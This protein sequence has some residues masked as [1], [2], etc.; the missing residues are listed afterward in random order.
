[1]KRG[2]HS[3]GEKQRCGCRTLQDYWGRAVLHTSRVKEGG[4][5][6]KNGEP[7]GVGESATEWARSL[8]SSAILAAARSSSDAR[9]RIARR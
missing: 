4:R 7:S 3:P 2:L 6:G 9:R 8:S 5:R 1:M